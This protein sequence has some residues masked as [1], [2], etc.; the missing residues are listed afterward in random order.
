[1]WSNREWF[2]NGTLTG[3]RVQGSEEA[4]LCTQSS[5]ARYW[6]RPDAGHVEL[7]PTR[8]S[9]DGL[10][11]VLF[12]WAR[13]LGSIGWDR[14][15]CRHRARASRPTTWASR[16]G[17][18]PGTSTVALQ[19]RDMEPDSTTRFYQIDFLPSAGVEFRWGHGGGKRLPG[20]RS[21]VVQ[22]LGVALRPSDAHPETDNDRLTRGW[23]GG[24][25][26]RWIQ[27]LPVHLHRP[28]EVLQLHRE[29][30]LC[31]NSRGG[32]GIMP[33][34][35]VHGSAHFRRGGEPQPSYQRTHAVAQYVRA[36]PDELRPTGPTAPGMC[37]AI[38]TRRS[39]PW[40]PGSAGPSLPG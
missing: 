25:E 2:L 20:E 11:G 4:I 18:I 27:H 14:F 17:W 1:M 31:R 21:A 10:E 15:S 29:L 39:F 37:S 36:V 38:W 13:G 30:H 40:I 24:S 9:M 8:T 16:P 19:Y 6:Q 28:A 5:P 35:G 22:F 33:R 12:S 26:T 7:D 34:L 23:A 32:W 3:S